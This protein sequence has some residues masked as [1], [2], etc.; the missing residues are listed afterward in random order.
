MVDLGVDFLNHFIG[1]LDILISTFEDVD[2]IEVGVFV[3]HHLVHI[4][5]VEVGVK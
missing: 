3:E 4:E 1:K 2:A 5:L